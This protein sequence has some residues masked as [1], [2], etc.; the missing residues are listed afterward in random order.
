M[1]MTNKDRFKPKQDLD[2][3]ISEMGNDAKNT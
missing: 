1:T 2:I 3:F